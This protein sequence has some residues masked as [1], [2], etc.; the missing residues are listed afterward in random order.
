MQKRQP[1]LQF[2]HWDVSELEPKASRVRRRS[3]RPRPRPDE[4]GTRLTVP[5]SVSDVVAE[6]AEEHPAFAHLQSSA[7]QRLRRE[8]ARAGRSCVEPPPGEHS[9]ADVI[10]V[11]VTSGEK[12]KGRTVNDN[13]PDLDSAAQPR[14]SGKPQLGPPQNDLY[15]RHAYWPPSRPTSSSMSTGSFAPVA[16]EHRPAVE[17]LAMESSGPSIKRKER[18]AEEG[19]P[20]GGAT[21]PSRPRAP[22]L[23]RHPERPHRPARHAA[24]TELPSSGGVPPSANGRS[25]NVLQYAQALASESSTARPIQAARFSSTVQDRRAY[26]PSRS[27][28]RFDN[29]Q[30]SVQATNPAPEQSG[31]YSGAFASMPPPSAA[32]VQVLWSASIPSASLPTADCRVGQQFGVQQPLPVNWGQS[33]ATQQRSRSPT[34]LSSTGSTGMTTLSLCDSGIP[35]RSAVGTPDWIWYAEAMAE[36]AT[37]AASRNVPPFSGFEEGSIPVNATHTG[38]F[39]PEH[40]QASTISEGLGLSPQRLPPAFYAPSARATSSQIMMDAVR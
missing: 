2:V 9:N 28:M 4:S 15:Q 8:Q 5:R 21:P 12:R 37:R 17:S 3:S 33:S 10:L 24:S 19:P 40:W 29:Q 25:P 36:E 23:L 32:D 22:F 39:R 11:S 35:R 30:T 31:T 6:P 27:S 38:T 14:E 7:E 26:L 16:N 34:W 13:P 1:S 20:L 18:P